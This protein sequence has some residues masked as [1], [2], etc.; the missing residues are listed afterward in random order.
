M[1]IGL[2]VIT[3]DVA[4]RPWYVS[5]AVNTPKDI[6][7]VVDTSVDMAH[8]KSRGSTLLDIAREA[9]VTVFDTLTSFDHVSSSKRL[10]QL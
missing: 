2:L 7:V 3:P 6:V 8:T 1:L 10:V 9:V 4:C 5:L